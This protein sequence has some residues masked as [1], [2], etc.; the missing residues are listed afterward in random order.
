MFCREKKK[1]KESSF[2]YQ[3]SGKEFSFPTTLAHSKEPL[4]SAAN[5]SITADCPVAAYDS[6]LGLPIHLARH[7]LPGAE[8]WNKCVVGGLAKTH[9]SHITSV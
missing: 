2:I 8:T 4:M 9:C 1:K 5:A 7:W 3:T 6:L